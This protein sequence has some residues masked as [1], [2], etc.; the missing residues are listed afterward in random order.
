MEQLPVKVDEQ[1]LTG[2]PVVANESTVQA[3]RS[4]RRLV[5]AG[6][7]IIL[8]GFGGLGAWAALAPLQSA[9]LAPGVVKVSSGRKIIQHL[10]G[11]IVKEILVKEGQEVSAGQVLIRLDDTIP[12]TRVEMLRGRLD[13]LLIR[14]ARLEAERSGADRVAIPE[15]LEPRRDEPEVAQLL[16]GEERVFRS[17]RDLLRGQTDVYR[18]RSQQAE[19]KI[20]GLQDQ[21][22][23]VRTQLNYIRKEIKAATQLLEKGIYEKPKYYALKRTEAR[24][25][26]QLG[27]YR[28][29]IAETRELIIE[30]QLRV[31][32]L[33]KRTQK[34]IN[35]QLQ[36][37]RTDI[38]DLRDQLR[39][40]SDTLARTEIVAPEA[41]TV[42]GLQVHTI[43]GVIKKGASILGIVP[44]DD[45]L[46]IEARVRIEDIDVVHRGLEAEVRLTAFNMRTTPTL[47]GKVTRV[48]ADRFEDPRTGMAYYLAEVAIDPGHTN[49]LE[50]FPGMSAQVYL[51]TGKRT[52]M[53]Y[54]LKPI[55]DSIRKGL[56]EQ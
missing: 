25:S 38:F 22:K 5:M 16:A 47:P 50:L 18:Q 55:Q 43:N 1:T 56:L 27:A 41:G 46:I 40:A 45:R 23:S 37:A 36:K 52:T 53:E 12:R 39:V 31:I 49:D 29:K 11:G 14:A 19:E 3:E 20:T 26:G 6:F 54:L 51:V 21:M 8:L 2:T 34:E 17:R 32:E 15:E 28:S 48:S 35:A 44:R 7:L 13:R 9:A 30:N 24:L 33:E 4:Q 10:E 42:V